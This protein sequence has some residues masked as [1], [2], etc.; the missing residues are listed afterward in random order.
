MTNQDKIKH[1]YWRAGFGLSL[2]ELENRKNWSISKAVQTLLA[3][4]KNPSPISVNENISINYDDLPMDEQEMS[5]IVK[6]GIAARLQNV[7]WIERMANPQHSPLLERMS[8]FWH[9]HFAC[10]AKSPKT[11]V[12]QL[13]VI[14][15]H[16]LGNFKDLVLAIAKDPAMIRFLNNQQN[17]KNSPNENFARELMELFTI[18]RGNYTENDIK[19]AARAFTGWTSNRLGEFVFRYRQHDYGQKTF[20]GKTGDLD[21]EDIIDIILEKPE[22]AQFICTKIYRYFVNHEVDKNRVRQLA[23]QFYN[24][25]Y[26]IEQIM[27]SIFQSDWFYEAQNIGTKIKSPVELVA[28]M[29]RSIEVQFQSPLAL[30]F[31]QKALGQMLYKPPSVAGWAGGKQWIDNSTLMLRLN[32]VAYLFQEA[33]LNFRVKDEFE[34]Q[35]RGRAQRKIQATVDLSKITRKMKNLSD[36]EIIDELVNLLL[37]RP[38]FSKKEFIQTNSSSYSKEDFI[39][40]AVLQIMS[41]PEYQL[42]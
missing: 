13:N 20:M 3:E 18:G 21:G 41:L 40:R 42:C 2:S 27:Q 8:L 9:G 4:A 36:S 11:A 10:I 24:S 30:L 1:L 38:N 16:A 7:M 14:R 34:S 19:E 33:E 5:P 31:V 12:Q 32:L 37:A 35:R 6:K 15:Q 39:K 17:K 25:N 29:M 22:T 26:N 23:N 28:G